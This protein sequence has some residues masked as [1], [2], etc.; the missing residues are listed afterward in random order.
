MEWKGVEWRGEEKREEVQCDE[1]VTSTGQ[2]AADDTEAE[3]FGFLL[4]K[5]DGEHVEVVL[6]LLAH[7]SVERTLRPQHADAHLSAGESK[8]GHRV[9]SRRLPHVLT[10]DLRV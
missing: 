4:L 3:P 5:L 2:L 7:C 8:R 9:L 1:Y 6:L 10:V